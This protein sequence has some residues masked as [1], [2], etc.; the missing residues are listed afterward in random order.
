MREDYLSLRMRS[1]GSHHVGGG[2]SELLVDHTTPGRGRPVCRSRTRRALRRRARSSSTTDPWFSCSMLRIGRRVRPTSSDSVTGNIEDDVEVGYVARPARFLAFE[3]GVR[4][5]PTSP[6][7]A[8]LRRSVRWVCSLRPTALRTGEYRLVAAPLPPSRDDRAHCPPA[9][10][11]A[12]PPCLQ[13]WAP[14]SI[15]LLPNSSSVVA[16]DGLQ[17]LRATRATSRHGVIS[18]TAICRKRAFAPGSKLTTNGGSSAMNMR[19]ASPRA[20]A[21]LPR[22]PSCRRRRNIPPATAS[23]PHD[24]QHDMISPFFDF[25][26]PVSLRRGRTWQC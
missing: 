8:R 19:A 22:V 6:A 12:V 21:R 25:L 23:A 9:S 14:S 4:L 24:P 13:L 26:A 15:C 10:P 7:E 18:C 11:F 3:H 2:G 1:A 5:R 16:D 17:V 20:E